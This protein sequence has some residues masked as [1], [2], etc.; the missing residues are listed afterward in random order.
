MIKAIV[1]VLF[2]LV[3]FIGLS[4]SVLDGI[5]GGGEP[6][7]D[8]SQA[9][10]MNSDALDVVAN[11]EYPPG[12]ISVSNEGRVFFT[13]HPEAK[14][15][16]N[17]AELIDGKAIPLDI[18]PEIKL[19]S[20]LSL[21]VD[22]Q[23]RLW[24]LDFAEHGMATPQIAAIDLNTM[25]LAH[26]FE[27]PS[28]I[29]GM[30]SHLNDFQVSHDGN[31]IYIADASI[32][33]KNPALIVYDVENKVA[34]R[35]LEGHDSVK[36]DYFVPV[37]DKEKM[38]IFGVF[39]IRPGVDSIALDRQEKWLYFAPVTDTYLHRLALKDLHNTELKP[40][41][42]AERV[43]RFAKKSMSDGI[44]TDDAGN[45]YISDLE[46]RAINRI[47]AKGKFETLLKDEK[48]RWPDGFSFGPDGWLYVANSALNV[49]I[50][51]PNSYIMEQGPY[52]IL[53]FKPD[54]SGYP[55]H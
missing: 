43:E 16:V 12:N 46:H 33:K 36:P 34:R 22:R 18:P 9:P 35:L 4:A 25:K 27:F 8:L 37:V 32:L 26:H 3:L 20:V 10:T 24:L 39:A 19:S 30:G 7:P 47:S 38:L 11:L 14:P 44:T 28:D 52:Q 29:A 15:P 21:R 54:S 6:F 17:I 2:S 45:I 50:A 53:R 51:K 41:Q 1:T 5:Y 23:N 42:L 31:F 48:L 40:E 55:G 49:V 13:F